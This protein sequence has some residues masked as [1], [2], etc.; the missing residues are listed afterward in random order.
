M[1]FTT[2]NLPVSIFSEKQKRDGEP[3]RFMTITNRS[4]NDFKP[5]G[6]RFQRYPSAILL[7][8]PLCI[9][10]TVWGS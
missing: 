2:L 5:P 1:I 3:Y 4:R 10:P 9:N 8:E 7:G 6:L